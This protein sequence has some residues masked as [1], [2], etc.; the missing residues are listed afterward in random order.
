MEHR[1]AGVTGSATGASDWSR[2]H[3]D[4]GDDGGD[5]GATALV[6]PSVSVFC[7]VLLFV[8]CLLYVVLV[9]FSPLL[10]VHLGFFPSVAH[11][12]SDV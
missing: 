6:F 4:S 10:C 7:F 2:V 11:P 8:C 3:V 5:T 1:A 12:S 9:S